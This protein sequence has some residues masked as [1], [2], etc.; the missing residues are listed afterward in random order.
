LAVFEAVGN[1]HMHTPYS[2][3]TKYHAQIAEDAIAA[4]LDFVVV[5][6]HNIWVD[7]VDGYY[8]NH[9]GRV[10]LITGEEIHDPRRNPQVSHFL[11]L[12]AGKELSQFG[13]DPQKLIDETREAGGYGFLA[14]PFDPDV[15]DIDG[16]SL[17]WRDWHVEGFSG[18]EIWNYMS[19]FKGHL[20]NRLQAIRVVLNPD[21][22]IVGPLQSTLAKWDEL[23]SQGKRV[24]GLGGSDAHAL[25]YSL[26]PLSRVIFPYE[27][28]F[29]AVNT[30]ILTRQ[31]F[32]GDSKH[33][34]QMVLDSIGTGNSWIGY[35]AAHITCGFR[36]SGQSRTKGIM[37]DEIKLDAAATLQVIAPTRCRIRMIRNGENVADCQNDVSL[38]FIPT[39][40]GAYRVECFIEHRGKERGWIFSNPIYLR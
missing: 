31:E 11:A 9:V 29:R 23:L 33:D 10:L 3:G 13:D 16:S 25:S 15:A 40:P 37:G 5:T 21:R 30:H 1:V 22:Y 18:L 12:G 27:F 35:D 20:R 24:A 17:G 2:D 7:G 14:H 4:G 28:L 32:N 39:E 8:E 34:K 26:G 38:T 36:F 6:D 19:N